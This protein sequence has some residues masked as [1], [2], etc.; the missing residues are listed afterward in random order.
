VV[1]KRVVPVTGDAPLTV[2]AEI[3]VGEASI[4]RVG[5]VDGVAALALLR[6]DRALEARTKGQTLTSD[7]VA[8]TVDAAALDAFDAAAKARSA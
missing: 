8:L 2:G 5:S 3:M 1:R 4:G 7:G 6:L